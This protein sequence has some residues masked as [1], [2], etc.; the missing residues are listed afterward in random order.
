VYKNVTH[1]IRVQKFYEL[2]N[3]RQTRH[4]QNKCLPEAQ[5]KLLKFKWF[6]KTLQKGLTW[7]LWMI[8]S[9]K[10]EEMNF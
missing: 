4:S 8:F 1:L 3:A 7:S 2:D 5:L 10:N 6:E 9:H